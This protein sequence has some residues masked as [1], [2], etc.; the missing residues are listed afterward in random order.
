MKKNKL[1]ILICGIGFLI[2]MVLGLISIVQPVKFMKILSAVVGIIIIILGICLVILGAFRKNQMEYSSFKMFLGIILISIG[3]IF[4]SFPTTPYVFFCI[5]F[6]IWA[7]ISGVFKMSMCVQIK[8]SNQP[9][10]VILCSGI[11]HF[12]FG[13]LL[14]IFPIT[15]SAFCT[16]LMGIYWV[17]ISLCF[18]M[19]IFRKD[20][21]Y[22]I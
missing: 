6:G 16:Q 18:I 10:G 20:N 3:T 9:I 14:I 8:K 12:I 13:I 2:F 22:L 19:T 4:I 7:I 5:A 11:L 1:E 21:R 15:Y 17:Y